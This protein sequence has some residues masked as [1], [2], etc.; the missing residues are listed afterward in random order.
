MSRNLSV[1]ALIAVAALVAA[2]GGS[3]GD[4]SPSAAASTVN[5]VLQE[6]AVTP[7][8]ASVPAGSVTFN[9]NNT[10]PEDIH[11]FVVI[12]SDLGAANLPVDSDG[13]VTEEG[14]GMTVIGEIEDIE[15]GATQSTTLDLTPGK[16][17]LICNIL[18][19]EADG[20]LEAH[21]QVGMRT[22]FEVK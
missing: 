12:K 2:C 11:E 14:E 5:V 9:V 8:V 4:A 21:Y 20:S 22:D 3:S 1:G 7:D 13:V 16:Y 6:F 18:Q 15:V 17:A 10:G 19:T